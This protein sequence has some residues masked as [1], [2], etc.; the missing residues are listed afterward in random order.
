MFVLSDFL[1]SCT[2]VFFSHTV[3][4]LSTHSCIDHEQIIHSVCGIQGSECVFDVL[5]VLTW[6]CGY[7][8][9][10]YIYFRLWS[11]VALTRCSTASTAVACIQTSISQSFTNPKRDS[12]FFFTYDVY[13]LIPTLTLQTVSILAGHTKAKQ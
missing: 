10:F 5:G 4:S 2:C 13:C 9:C 12:F 11:R 3:F 1:F 6:T 8:V 7:H